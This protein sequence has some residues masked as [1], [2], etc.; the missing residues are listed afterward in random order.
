[1]K[2]WRRKNEVCQQQVNGTFVLRADFEGLR[3]PVGSEHGKAC[4][5]KYGLAQLR[6]AQLVIDH[7]D[8]RG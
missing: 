7:Q 6:D 1:L 5:L 2:A 3:T 8:G 4:L